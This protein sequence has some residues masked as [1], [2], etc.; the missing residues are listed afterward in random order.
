MNRGKNIEL[1]QKYYRDYK[2]VIILQIHT[3]NILY[4]YTKL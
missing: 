4:I 3:K 2:N 1:I